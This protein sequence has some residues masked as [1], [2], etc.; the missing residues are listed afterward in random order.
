MTAPVLGA[1]LPARPVV[2]ISHMRVTSV[3]SSPA[4]AIVPSAPP[5]TVADS[6]QSFSLSRGQ[7]AHFI[8]QVQV[9]Y[10]AS[11][12]ASGLIR[13]DGPPAAVSAG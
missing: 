10:L 8:E 5:V 4:P 3:P 1:S 13:E 11:L 6:S 7:M 2:P 12:Q 9:Q